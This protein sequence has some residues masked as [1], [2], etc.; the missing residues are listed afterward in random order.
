MFKPDKIEITGLNKVPA[1][2]VAKA[3]VSSVSIVNDQLVINGS[4]LDGVSSVKIT[5][6]S[7]F[8]ESF[9]IE[10]KSSSNLIANGLKNISFALGSVFSLIL[11]DAFGASSFEVTFTLQDGAVTASKLSSMGAGVGQVMK[12]NGTTWIPTDLSGLTYMG[13]WDAAAGVSVGPDAGAG[14]TAGE[15]YVVSNA[16]TIDVDGTSLWAAGD[17]VVWNGLSW[18]KIDNSTG[19]TT[20]NGRSGTV[21]P[22]PN[23]YTWAQINKAASSLN[24][25]ADVD[26]TGV[27]AGKVLKWDGSK[28]AVADDVSGGG[29]GSVTS[30]EIADGS[31]M[32]VDVSASAAIAQSKIQNL[33]TD[34][35]SKLPLAGGTMTGNLNMGANNIVTS[36]LVDGVDVSTLASQVSTNTT[37]V[38]GK[39]PTIL[40][41]MATQYYRGDKTW[42]TLNTDAVPQGLLNY[43]YEA[44]QAR[45]D[46]ISST[47]TNGDTN[48]APTSDAVFDALALKQDALAF[49][50]VNKAGDAM[51]GN[52]T[53]NA[54]SEARFAD[55]DSSNY[56]ALRSPTTVASNLTFTLPGVDGS[57]GQV[58]S[59]NGSGALSWI[60]PA[61]GT[62]DITDVNAGTGLSGG[63]AS[64]SVTLNVDVGTTANKI[65]Q[66]DGSGKLPALDGSNLTNLP[67]NTASTVLTGFTTGA[68]TAVTNTDTVET[69]VEKL[70]GQI[71][72]NDT[73]IAANASAIA[74]KENT[75]TKGNLTEDTS[76]VLTITGGTGSV[77]GSGVSILVKQATSTISG[78]LSSADWNIFNDKLGASNVDNTTIE[79]S[80]GNLRVKDGGITSAKIAHTLETKSADYTVTTADINKTFLV[81]G[82]TTITL[83]PA[84]TAGSGFTLTVKN[85]DASEKVTIDANA[86]ELI[87]GSEV[88]S[89]DGQYATVQLISNGS[90][91]FI[92]YSMGTIGTGS[93]ACPTGF[94]EV[95]GN[96]TLG[97]DDFCVMQ[98]EAKNVASTPASTATGSPWVSIN[99]TDAFSECAS[100]SESGFTGTFALI[101]NP[102]WMTIARD[103]EDVASNWSGGSVG[104]GH[105][106][107]GWS[108]E[109]TDDGFQ[110]TA[111]APSTGS[112]CLYNTAANTCASTGLHKLKRTHQLSN[113]SEIWDFA[114]N[115][116]EWVDWSTTAGFTSG[117][118]NGTA[119]WQELTTLSGSVTANDVQS[120]GGYTST[121]NAGRWYGDS[122]GAALRGGP[123]NNGTVA[124]AFTL[125]LAYA[126][127]STSTNFGFRCV[128]RP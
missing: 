114:G 79:V 110:N 126:P 10:S 50:P 52:L 43:Y 54:Q 34:L 12:W 120:S 19:V 47:I 115:V 37:T 121:Q 68:D 61:T 11:A 62:G 31:I 26:T 102:E 27:S 127:S 59:T 122:G 53:L 103:L 91:W 46:L 21:T 51:T 15:Y 63:G 60:T 82:D 38:S 48:K 28:W 18:D 92:A 105:L 80:G 36:G 39:E 100:M 57:S 74:G 111:V 107:R 89:L 95:L 1:T 14:T 45:T 25:I 75:L 117:P 49:T 98:Y 16:G 108:A 94:V 42:Q 118:T 81:S 24:D 30:T 125:F 87:D 6:P 7:G 4:D 71:A 90:N 112:S 104:S 23:D 128:Y 55:A 85:T 8:N 65:V 56:V 33:T 64:G 93:L 124:G 41:G 44:S 106:S 58:L 119:S 70:Q 113:G 3:T 72:G 66:L 109:T 22:Q 73:A 69:A 77:I 83:P 116:W 9:A 123:W 2:R 84:A 20:F 99:A 35:A 29:A 96:A 5:G 67:N 17:W 88:K 40:G 78:Y 86:S 97:T 76:S 32:D 101:S 13:T